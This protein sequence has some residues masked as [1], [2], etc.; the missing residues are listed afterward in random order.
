MRKILVLAA[1]AAGIAGPAQAADITGA[2]ATFKAI[3]P[4]FESRP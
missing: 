2:G 1:V 4:R 3:L